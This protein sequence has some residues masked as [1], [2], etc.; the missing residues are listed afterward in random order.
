MNCGPMRGVAANSRLTATVGA[1]LFVALVVEAVSRSTTSGRCSCSTR[2]SGCSS[3]PSRVLKLCTTGYR[4]VKYYGHDPAYRRKG[5]PHPILRILGPLVVASTVVLLGPRRGAAGRRPGELRHVGDRSPGE[6]HRVD[7]GHVDPRVGP[8]RRDMAADRVRARSE[9]RPGTRPR[10]AA[11]H[12]GRGGPRRLGSRSRLAR[13]EQR[14]G[15]APP[16]PG[17]P[18]RDADLIK[19]VGQTLK[20]RPH[21]HSSPDAS[22]ARFPSRATLRAGFRQPN[23]V[24]W[25]D[26][27]PGTRRRGSGGAARRGDHDPPHRWVEPRRDLGLGMP[28]RTRG[29]SPLPCDCRS[30][31]R[32]AARR[33]DSVMGTL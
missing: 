8:H 6:F 19:P 1:I 31:S 25:S 5:P 2:S 10:L 17:S 23:V 15:A 13:L 28:P 7:L 21:A 20:S 26:G 11:H 16:R 33:C 4:F 27:V 30:R 3:C 22:W 24:D 14:L 29:Q 18:W 12:H 32:L 9:R